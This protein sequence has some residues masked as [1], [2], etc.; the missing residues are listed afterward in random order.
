MSTSGWVERK[1]TR[2]GSRG[3]TRPGF[4]FCHYRSST[5]YIRGAPAASGKHPTGRSAAGA[6]ALAAGHAGDRLTSPVR[7]Q[8]AAFA[9]LYKSHILARATRNNTE[10]RI[11]MAPWERNHSQTVYEK[12][13]WTCVRY[14]LC[15]ARHV[16]RSAL[17]ALGL[18]PTSDISCALNITRSFGVPK[19]HKPGPYFFDSILPVVV[20]VSS[21]P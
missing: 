14:E 3:L 12:F 10:I 15:M 9:L 4:G 17:S 7:G 5:F 8:L 18:S 16:P 20:V 1:E 6:A 19:Y 21:T 11:R 13:R 2:P